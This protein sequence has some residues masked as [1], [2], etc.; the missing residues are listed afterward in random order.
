LWA[1]TTAFAYV[2]YI[3]MRGLSNGLVY[4]KELNQ[5]NR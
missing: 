2:I 1:V 5:K 3:A 4:V